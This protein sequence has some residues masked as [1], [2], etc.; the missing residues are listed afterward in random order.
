M[1]KAIA[2]VV[3]TGGCAEAY[4]P[5]HVDVRVIDLDNV[6][7][8][9]DVVKLPRDVGFEKLVDDAGLVAGIDF[10]WED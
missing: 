7:A 9:D 10:D 2:L 8:G 3:V 1:D 6:K 4:E 5:E